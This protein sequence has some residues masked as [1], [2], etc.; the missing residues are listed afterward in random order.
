M[1]EEGCLSIPSLSAPV[2]RPWSI[3]IRY[4]DQELVR[5][6]KVFSG[7]TARMIQH[8]YDH[9]EGILYIDYLNPVARK[10]AVSKLNRIRRGQIKTGYLMRFFR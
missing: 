5:R 8:E 7:T 3:E 4:F 10:L 6:Q 9:T 2:T 1:E